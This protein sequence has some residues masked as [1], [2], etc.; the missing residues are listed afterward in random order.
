MYIL[1]FRGVVNE[2]VLRGEYRTDQ[3]RN[4][5]VSNCIRILKRGLSQSGYYR[6]LQERPSSFFGKKKIFCMTKV[7][8]CCNKPFSRS[9]AN[10]P[11]I[12]IFQLQKKFSCDKSMCIYC[13]LA[14]FVSIN[15]KICVEINAGFL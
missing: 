10:G 14:G 2:H 8:G 9:Y 7:S 12:F 15:C 1:F 5:R 4:S 11:N 3:K 6:G 13:T